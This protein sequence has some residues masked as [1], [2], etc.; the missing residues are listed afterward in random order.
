MQKGLQIDLV[1][2]KL[3]WGSLPPS[4]LKSAWNLPLTSVQLTHPQETITVRNKIDG[5]LTRITVLEL[6]FE[7]PPSDV[8]EQRCRMDLI[9]YVVV[10]SPHSV[11]S[12]FQQ[13]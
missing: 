12:S 10:L 5:L 1:L 3:S 11:L 4:V 6:L 9:Q 7:T 2:S 8:G 13:A